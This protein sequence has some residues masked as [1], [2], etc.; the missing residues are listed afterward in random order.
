MSDL[1]HHSGLTKFKQLGFLPRGE[2][3]DNV[4]GTC[5]FCGKHKFFVNPETGAWDCKV[6][7]REGGV[8]TFVN[9]I[10]EFAAEQ[11]KG[12]EAAQLSRLKSV[13][14]VAMKDRGMGFLPTS[15][16]YTLPVYNIDHSGVW[17]MQVFHG[18]K[19][20]GLSDHPV[21]LLGW[22]RLDQHNVVWLCEGA[23]DLMAMH[24]MMREVNEPGV[25]LAVPGAG[26]FKADWAHMFKGKT[27]HVMYDNDEPGKRGAHK[28]NNVIGSLVKA[29]DFIHW[30]KGTSDGYD[31]RDWK[32]DHEG[33]EGR[34]SSLRQFLN[35]EPPECQ[36]PI[37]AAKKKVVAKDGAQESFERVNV[38]DERNGPYIPVPTVI[39]AY[40]KWLYLPSVDVLSVMFGTVI[41]NYL[42]GDPLWTFLVAPPG[43][44]KTELLNT[45]S[46]A[47]N[48]VTTSSLTPRSLVSGSQSPGGGDPSLLPKLNGKTLVVKDFTTIL[49]M[50]QMVRDEITSILR[51]AYDGKT[52]KDFGNGIHRF[53]ETKFGFISGVTP[54]HSLYNEGN[55]SLGERFLYF[56][57]PTPTDAR[58]REAY[59]MQAHRN[60]GKENEMR[61]ELA[62]MG[63]SVLSYAFPNVPIMDEAMVRKTISLAQLLAKLRGTVIRDKFTREITHQAFSEMG[64]RL[65]KQFTKMMRGISMF[66]GDQVISPY[67]YNIV[68]HMALSSAPGNLERATRYMWENGCECTYLTKDIAEVSELPHGVVERHL[69]DLRALGMF[70]RR[71]SGGLGMSSWSLTDDA[72]YLIETAEAYK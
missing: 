21:G 48:I 20:L 23:W 45:I 49:N 46:Q 55:T 61:S 18:G 16:A 4:L 59:M 30:P 24:S 42:D 15:G 9:E 60:A 51:D 41:A 28:V 50:P 27:V 6:C 44:A 3:G 29:I 69:E 36:M 47:P 12:L 7:L 39:E 10:A 33:E 31:V 67:A 68:K 32:V 19:L 65:T 17:T 22:E 64:T 37:R 11:F 72:K 5:P 26:T 63:T 40:R 13:S 70:S 52:E 43:G 62:A 8:K 34:W 56:N 66:Q 71:T 1:T 58:G 25:L 35:D 14:V 53:Y 54:A 2:S 38:I 57:I